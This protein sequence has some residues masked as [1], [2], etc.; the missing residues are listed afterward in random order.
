[1][2]GDQFVRWGWRI[3]FWL[4]LIMVAIG[5]WIR[6]GILETPVFRQ[7]I[8]EERVART[9][10]LEVLKR[11]PKEAALVAL[12]RTCQMVPAFVYGVFFFTYGMKMAGATRDFLLI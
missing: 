12:A 10:V 6:L 9:P 8:E 11:Q 7:V 3:P 4:S 2:C 5:L 1:M